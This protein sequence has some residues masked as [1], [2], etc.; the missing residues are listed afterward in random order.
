M[1]P[2]GIT[3]I[4]RIPLNANG[5]VDRAALRPAEATAAAAVVEPSG[6]VEERIARIFTDLLGG[7]VGADT[8]FFRAGGNSILAIRLIANLRSVF[9]IDL[10]IRAVFEAPTV[11]DLAAL[12]EA[13]IT[14][15]VE[16]MS[17]EDLIAQTS[18]GAVGTS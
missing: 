18:P 13:E 7:R 4:D 5:K 2:D 11:A 17:E 6:I 15:E 8:H 12:I 10:P 16:Q 3:T 9:E 14:A 1:V